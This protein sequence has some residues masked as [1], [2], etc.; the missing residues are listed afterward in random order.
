MLLEARVAN[1][2]ELLKRMK[3]VFDSGELKSK[4]LALVLFSCWADVDERQDEVNE[5][6]QEKGFPSKVDE[7]W[8]IG[9]K[10]NLKKQE[11]LKD[12]A[13][14]DIAFLEEGKREF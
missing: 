11:Q 7:D 13:G 8:S 9:K 10:D 1:H 5:V 4:G 14:E 6:I 12:W 3:F 2:L